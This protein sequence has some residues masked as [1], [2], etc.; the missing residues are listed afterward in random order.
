ML[1][2][3]SAF[4]LVLLLLGIT[5][6]FLKRFSGGTGARPSGVRMEVVQRLALGPKQ[7][8]AVVRIGDRVMAVSLGEG[9]VR[10]ILELDEEDLVTAAGGESTPAPFPAGTETLAAFTRA[11]KETP[12]AQR[13]HALMVAAK[14]SPKARRFQ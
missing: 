4:G 12:G 14:E 1:G 6:R 13:L 3:V 8:L 7:G 9:G 11:A 2:F 5:L 10:P